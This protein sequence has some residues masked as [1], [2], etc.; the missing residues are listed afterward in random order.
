MRTKLIQRAVVPIFVGIMVGCAASNQ[1]PQTTALTAPTYYVTGSNGYRWSKEEVVLLH[2]YTPIPYKKILS[3]SGLTL[4][5]FIA[6]MQE[7]RAG[8]H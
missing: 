3:I 5:A 2:V 4:V 6:G 8:L 1:Q 7:I